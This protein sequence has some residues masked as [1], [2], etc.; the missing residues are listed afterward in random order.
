MDNP[1]VIEFIDPNDGEVTYAV[2]SEDNLRVAIA[3]SEK[4]AL[5]VYFNDDMDSVDYIKEAGGEY[6]IAL[7]AAEEARDA[8]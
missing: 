7:L 6:A 8:A 4:H 2:F 3:T 1:T 5:D